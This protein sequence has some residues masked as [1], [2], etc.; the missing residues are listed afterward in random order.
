M[1]ITFG[2]RVA[3]A[4]HDCAIIAQ[5]T[6][7]V[8]S[9]RAPREPA[10]RARRMNGN[11]ATESPQCGVRIRRIPRRRK[12]DAHDRQKRSSRI[13][14]CAGSR[15]EA[16]LEHDEVAAA[17]VV[18]QFPLVRGF[19]EFLHFFRS[20]DP[21]VGMLRVDY[22][23]VGVGGNSRPVFAVIVGPRVM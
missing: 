12:N 20:L 23:E 15:S 22:D 5:I 18:E 13:L 3:S 1:T 4:K 8:G 7:A 21:A 19:A 2:L 10:T 17:L 9:D 14:L 11:N 16:A 6:S